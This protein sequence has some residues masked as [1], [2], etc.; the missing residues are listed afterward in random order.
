MPPSPTLESPPTVTCLRIDRDRTGDANARGR[1]LLRP[2]VHRKAP[3][4]TAS[5]HSKLLQQ[6]C[7]PRTT[8]EFVKPDLKSALP[9]TFPTLV[10]LEL[11][12]VASNLDAIAVRIEK[13]NRPI[14]GN[15]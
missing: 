6:T 10:K 7:S 3:S 2:R 1:S 11:V 15:H 8:I 13:T 9:F 5:F 4:S 12:R 14:T